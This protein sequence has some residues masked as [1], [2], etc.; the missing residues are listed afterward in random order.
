MESSDSGAILPGRQPAA[1][2]MFANRAFSHNV[3]L[4]AFLFFNGKDGYMFYKIGDLF[5]PV[6]IGALTAGTA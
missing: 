5:V 2:K 4:K 3:K 1:K 6:I